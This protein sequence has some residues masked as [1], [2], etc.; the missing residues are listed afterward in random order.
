MAL[1]FINESLYH[2]LSDITDNAENILSRINND[3]IISLEDSISVNILKEKEKVIKKQK[4]TINKL[5]Y[6][7][8]IMQQKLLEKNIQ[9]TELTD[10]INDKIKLTDILTKQ[11]ISLQN[12]NEN[13][14]NKTS[15]PNAFLC[16][17]CMEK[18]K[19]YIYLPCMHLCYCEDCIQKADKNTCPICR[20]K[21]IKI[22]K[23]FLD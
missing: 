23:I 2:L 22:Q 9:M 17:A 10:I 16:N 3:V 11:I 15:N 5:T 18:N 7:L 14:T 1:N 8:D 13:E 4:T 19:Q 21:N 12:N 6:I 20:N